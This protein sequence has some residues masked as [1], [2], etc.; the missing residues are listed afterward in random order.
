MFILP[1]SYAKVDVPTFTTILIVASLGLPLHRFTARKRR[2][3][4]VRI[5]I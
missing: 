2:G 3:A 1:V 4:K 5:S